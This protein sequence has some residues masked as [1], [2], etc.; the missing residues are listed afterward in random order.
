MRC[1]ATLAMMVVCVSRFGLG[2][3]VQASDAISPALRARIERLKREVALVDTDAATI[4]GRATVLWDWANAYAMGGGQV[5]VNLPLAVAQ[6]RSD[7]DP[8]SARTTRRYGS[9]IDS[10]VRQMAV[11][12]EQ[13]DA[14]GPLTSDDTG[15]FL[16]DSYQTIRQVYT[17]GSL[18]LESGG[19]VLVARHFMSDHGRVQT[20]DPAADNYIT[21]GSSNREARF[22]VEQAPVAGM[23]GGFRGATDR[24]LFRL[25]GAR[26][27]RGDTVTVTY[28]DRSG[29]SRGFKVQSYS[30][31]AFQLPLYVDFD[32]KGDRFMLPLV[33][34]QVV[35]PRRGGR[36]GIRAV[37]GRGGG[38]V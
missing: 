13:A 35:G 2:E 26:L 27:A 24:L 3:E 21:I 9:V 34:Y 16:A 28:G 25:E 31:D 20:M 23:H 36:A 18:A 29:G 10:Y 32:G 30:N 19:G 5:P 17:V 1:F 22:R 4:Q 11:Y 37:G 38:I 12:D 15:P 8:V 14:I 6:V 33:A 7:T